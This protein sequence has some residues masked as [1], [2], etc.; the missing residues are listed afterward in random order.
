MLAKK[1]IK[2]STNDQAIAIHG[3]LR[4]KLTVV[5]KADK[6]TGEPA[7][8]AY[9]TGWDDA[10][11]AQTISP[12]LSA[13]SAA[14]IRTKHFGSLRSPLLPSMPAS[15]E[16]VIDMMLD[17]DG[18]KRDVDA[19][20]TAAETFKIDVRDFVPYW[21][22][23]VTM[24]ATKQIVSCGDLLLKAS[25]GSIPGVARAPHDHAAMAR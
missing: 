14:K 13:K 17:I 8:V 4:D 24:L 7:I 21:N 23:L 5:A 16:A 2:H 18:L 20:Q 12:E 9:V 25:D 3:L 6:D 19:L 15:Q 11:V 10:R 1:P 22:K